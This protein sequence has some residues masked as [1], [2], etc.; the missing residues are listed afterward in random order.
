MTK[1]TDQTKSQ[2]EK[3]KR[4]FANRVTNQV[5]QVLEVWRLLQEGKWSEQLTQDLLKSVERLHKNAERFEETSHQDIAARLKDVIKA[6]ANRGNKPSSEQLVQLNQD[7]QTLSKTALSQVDEDQNDLPLIQLKKP[8]YIALGD[9]E[10]TD[11]LVSQMRFFGLQTETFTTAEDFLSSSNHRHPAVIVIDADFGG[12]KHN[13]IKLIQEIQEARETQIPVMFFAHEDNIHIRLEAARAGG[14]DFYY[15][16]IDASQLIEKIETITQIVPNDPYRVLIVDDSKAQLH[17]T[18]KTL[19][20]AGMIT[21]AIHDPMEVFHALDSFDPE[22]IISDMYMPGCNGMELARVIRQQEKYVSLPIIYISAEDDIDKQLIAM[23]Q[24]GDDFLTKPIKPNHMVSTI[25]N[26]AERARALRSLMVRDSLTGLYNHTR[27]LRQLETEITR[28]EKS[29][30]PLCF[31]MLDIDH[32]KKVNDTYGHPIGDRVIKSLALLLKQRVRKS[33]TV[34]RYGGEEFAIVL[35][36]TNL[37]NASRI[38]NDLRERFAD[39]VQVA[40][41]TEFQVTFSC[42]ISCFQGGS[43]QNLSET[44]DRALYDAKEQGRNCIATSTT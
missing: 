37:E 28:L 33:D 14:V 41:E 42:G 23:T 21:H 3:L 35:P 5:R 8:V 17:Y 11:K 32:F 30:S 10:I 4:Y 40:G 6:I 34:G 2:R 31:A 25:K 18:Q 1:D 15:D 29:D 20:N 19:N 26:R 38:L 44:A 16:T 13:G 12:I 27:T 43:A 24:G 22:L 39:M 9:P 7:M 36:D